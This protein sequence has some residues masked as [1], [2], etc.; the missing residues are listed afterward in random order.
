[1]RRSLALIALCLI[2]TACS[3]EAIGRGVVGCDNPSSSILLAVQAVRGAE[4]MPCIVELPAGWTYEHLEARRGQARF[5]LHSDRVGERFLTVT[6]TPSCDTG[7]AVSSRSDEPGI[8]LF[9]DVA[10]DEATLTVTIIPEG[11]EDALTAEYAVLVADGVR[12]STLRHRL[13]LVTVDGGESPTATRLRR[14]LD[15]GQPALVVG[16]REQEERRVELHLPGGETVRSDLE[17][18]LLHIEDSL[19]DPRYVATWYYPFRDGCVTYAFDAEG[20]GIG[21]VDDDVAD[22]LTLLPVDPFR[23]V[24]ESEGFVIP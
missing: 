18:A 2:M 16:V 5:W 20:P 1:M 15:R 23:A 3:N 13:V 10:V 22:S 19:G 8:P 17:S 11:T 6:V 14:A 4:Y 24:A 7:A 9:M 12:G 21:R